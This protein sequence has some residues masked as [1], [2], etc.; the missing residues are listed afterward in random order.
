MANRLLL[1]GATGRLGMIF[2]AQARAAGMD[3][4][5]P[6]HAELALEDTAALSDFVLSHPADVVVNAAAMS[7]LEACLDDAYLAHRVNVMAPAAMALACRH[8][9]A[10]FVHLSTDYVLD[11][12]RGGMKGVSA[13]C[14]P[15]SVYG[16]SKWEAELQVMEGYERSL[17]VR[18]S[19]IC[20]NPARPSFIESICARALRGEPL[21][22]IADKQSM[23]THARDIARACL[24]LAQRADLS[25]IYHLCASGGALSWWDCANLTVEA[26]ME[27]GALQGGARLVVERQLLKDV[28]F[29]REERPRYTAMDNARLA[30]DVGFVMPSAEETVAAAV[31]DFLAARG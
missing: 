4:M 1:F 16:E 24:V 22:A 9:G 11:G 29:F 14:R 28:S 30:V 23:P 21:R 27:Q 2:A 6:L 19:W 25:G 15:V 7:G 10:R 12:R 31:R 13:K 18:V 5:A 3:V 20:G 8:S 17:I 26:L